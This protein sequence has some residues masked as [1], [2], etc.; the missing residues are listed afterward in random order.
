MRPTLVF[1][2]DDTLWD[3]QGLL[4][5]FEARIEALLDSL[6]G[7]ASRFRERFIAIENENI[8]TL[9]Y[10]F[11]SYV[12]SAAEAVAQHPEWRAHKPAVLGLVAELVAAMQNS[13][14]RVI[15]GVVPTLE[16]LRRADYRMVLLT[17][18]L[19]TEQ[20]TKLERSGL[21]EFFADVRI[22]P[23]KDPATYRQAARALGDATGGTLCMIGNS[24][25]S[26]IGPALAAGWRAIHVPAP[27]E[28]A[29]DMGEE[30]PSARFRRAAT[31]PHVADLIQSTDF[32][33]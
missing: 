8:P 7:T 22:V 16:R 15:R 10:G 12:F 23:R 20:R 31:F 24:M 17:R 30:T 3:E 11:P 27:R 25:R 19:E 18:G 4:Q 9:G 26:D 28:W 14:P 2:A 33:S 21:A 32:W 1:D 6:T 13:G 5:A 29:H